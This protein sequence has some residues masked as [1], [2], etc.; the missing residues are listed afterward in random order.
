MAR[1]TATTGWSGLGSCDVVIEAV[2]EELSVKHK[3]LAEFESAAGDQAIFAT[4]TS[5]IPIERI[6]ATAKHP[7]RVVGM[8]FFSPVQKMPLVEVVA[9]KGADPDAVATVAALAR[10]MGKTAIIVNDGPGFYVNR[11]LSAYVTEALRMLNEGAAVEALDRAMRDVGF[12]VGPLQ[13]LDEVG[14]DIALHVSE[15]LEAA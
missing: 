5:A 7:E 6:A 15:I 3:V 13:V 1:L 4:N 11:P 8:H 9:W 2:F 14:W 10:K 12:P